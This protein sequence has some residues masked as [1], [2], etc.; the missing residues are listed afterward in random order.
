[1]L[2]VL[3][4]FAVPLAYTIAFCGSLEAFATIWHN[5]FELWGRIMLFAILLLLIIVGAL[6]LLFK[7][8]EC[9]SE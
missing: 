4:V 2:W 5:V 1:M 7:I 9:E 8:D 3:V 6:I